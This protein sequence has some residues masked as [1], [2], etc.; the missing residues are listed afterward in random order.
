[1]TP[2]TNPHPVLMPLTL[3]G[4]SLLGRILLHQDTSRLGVP[5]KTAVKV[6]VTAVAVHSELSTAAASPEQVIPAPCL[7]PPEI[8]VSV[9]TATLDVTT[10]EDCSPP[11]LTHLAQYVRSSRPKKSGRTRVQLRW[12]SKLVSQEGVENAW[13]E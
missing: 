13:G 7:P 10:T 2:W 6:S 5:T 12:C 1:M 8:Q 3:V 9:S 4:L 11:I